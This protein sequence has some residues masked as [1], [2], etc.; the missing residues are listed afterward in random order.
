ML[1]VTHDF[2]S[3]DIDIA[4]FKISDKDDDSSGIPM[5]ELL[6]EDSSLIW[7]FLLDFETRTRLC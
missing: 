6:S 7:A 2:I 1:V 3:S 4:E 5:K